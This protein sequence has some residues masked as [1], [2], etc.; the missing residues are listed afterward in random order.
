MGNIGGIN[1]PP[2]IIPG[3]WHLSILFILKMST[4]LYIFKNN[5][6][7]NKKIYKIFDTKQCVYTRNCL[8]LRN[9]RLRF[10]K[11]FR[12]SKMIYRILQF[13]LFATS[14]REREGDSG[15][16]GANMHCMGERYVYILNRGTLMTFWLRCSSSKSLTI[17]F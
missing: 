5:N 11:N 16:L 13:F 3:K 4:I 6:F 15:I 14:I 7:V 1:L 17:H 8:S 9:F 10:T 12:I 2:P